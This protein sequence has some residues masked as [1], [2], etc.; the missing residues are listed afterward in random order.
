MTMGRFE[1]LSVSSRFWIVS[2]IGIGCIGHPFGF[3]FVLLD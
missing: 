2:L 1:A 3:S